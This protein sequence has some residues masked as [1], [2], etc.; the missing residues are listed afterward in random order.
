L[1]LRNITCIVIFIRIRFA[2]VDVVLD[3]RVGGVIRVGVVFDGG[4]EFRRTRVDGDDILQCRGG[5]LW[6]NWTI[7]SFYKRQFFCICLKRNGF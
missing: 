5:W 4:V 6:L 3:T 7:Q 1:N 2:L